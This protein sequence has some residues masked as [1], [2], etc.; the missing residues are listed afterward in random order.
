VPIQS[1]TP[2]PNGAAIRQWARSACLRS[3][4]YP[5]APLAGL[6]RR[7]AVPHQLSFAVFHQL[8]LQLPAYLPF[9]RTPILFARRVTSCMVARPSAFYNF[10]ALSD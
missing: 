2:I 1:P 9:V 5:P 7:I 4:S 6:L 10:A 3:A 8:I